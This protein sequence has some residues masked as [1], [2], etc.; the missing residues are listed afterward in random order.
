[1]ESDENR[2]IF[3]LPY[4]LW[5]SVGTREVESSPHTSTKLGNQQFGYVGSVMD[6]YISILRRVALVERY[7]SAGLSR[8]GSPTIFMMIPC[9]ATIVE[10]LIFLTL[11]AIAILDTAVPFASPTVVMV[12]ITII[13]FFA[14]GLVSAAAYKNSHAQWPQLIQH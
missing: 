14:I 1:M 6:E 10:T 13:M 9:P 8:R 3:Q 7:A 5:P 2:A 11:G 12:T 4:P